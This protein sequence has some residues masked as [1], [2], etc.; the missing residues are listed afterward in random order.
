MG[1]GEGGDSPKSDSIRRDAYRDMNE[2]VAGQFRKG[3]LEA[4]ARQQLAQLGQGQAVKGL[5]TRFLVAIGVGNQQVHGPI[6]QLPKLIPTVRSKPCR[7]RIEQIEQFLG[8][9]AEV[10]LTAHGHDVER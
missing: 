7:T 3:S 5:A 2:L 4:Q 9:S 10:A 1:R 6:V 8:A